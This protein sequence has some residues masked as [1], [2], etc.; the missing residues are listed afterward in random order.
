MDDFKFSDLEEL[1]NFDNSLKNSIN[2]LLQN[3][4]R[5]LKTG[6]IY[7]TL[8]ALKLIFNNKIDFPFILFD[9]N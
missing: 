3:L 2:E 9:D 5:K 1:F 7:H 6:I 4:E 8:K